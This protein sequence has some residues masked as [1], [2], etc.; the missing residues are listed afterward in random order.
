MFTCFLRIIVQCI[1]SPRL[2]RRAAPRQRHYDVITVTSNCYTLDTYYYCA[3]GLY[4]RRKILTHTQTDWIHILRIIWRLW[5]QVKYRQPDRQTNVNNIQ[6][7]LQLQTADDTANSA[8]R[9]PSLNYEAEMKIRG[10]GRVSVM[11]SLLFSLFDGARIK[12]LFFQ[13]EESSNECES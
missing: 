5:S 11:Y 1:V 7:L 10:L 3:V 8:L 4:G 6:I 13:S 12:C 2:P 9:G